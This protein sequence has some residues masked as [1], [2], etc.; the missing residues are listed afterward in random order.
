MSATGTGNG[1]GATAGPGGGAGLTASTRV[2]ALLG[3]PVEHSLSP[4]MQNAAFRAAGVDG[5]YVALRCDDDD[6][7]G[8]LRGLALAGG[9]GNVTIPHKERAAALVEEKTDAVRST[10]ACNTFWSEDGVVHGDNTDVV[11]FQRAAAKLVGSELADARILLVGAGGAARAAVVGLLEDGAD[12]VIIVNRTPQRARAVASR[13]G[14]RR[15]RVV[16]G[17]DALEG[18]SFDLA[19]NATSLGLGDDEPLPIPPD[20]LDGIGAVLDLV[21]GPGPT[22]LVEEA[23]KRG[24]PA[25]DGVEMLVAQGVAS[26]RRWWGTDPSLDAMR[27]GLGRTTEPAPSGSGAGD[28][29]G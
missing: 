23:R 2:L 12:E 20:R 14:D 16:E 29:G 9:G 22:P 19:V 26:F 27:R 25:E 7:E 18:E 11:G 6:V 3:D 21:Y 5:I 13:A 1:G 15:V 10:G 8:L 28:P 17:H 24:M 4:R